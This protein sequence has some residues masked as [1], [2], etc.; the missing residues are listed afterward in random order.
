MRC[1]VDA[2]NTGRPLSEATYH[3]VLDWL[4][5]HAQTLESVPKD[6]KKSASRM[7]IKVFSCY[8]QVPTPSQPQ[9]VSPLFTYAW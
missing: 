6:F 3:G 2:V 7:K 8:E 4:N 1:A 5:Q 9:W